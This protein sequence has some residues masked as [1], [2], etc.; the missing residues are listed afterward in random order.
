MN[1]IILNGTA[2][3]EKINST[4]KLLYNDLTAISLK[5]LYFTQEIEIYNFA[6][7]EYVVLIRLLKGLLV[8]TL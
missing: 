2:K 8:A 4:D 5:D 3:Y 7:G 6:V 1:L